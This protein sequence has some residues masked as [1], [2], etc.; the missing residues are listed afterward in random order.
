MEST[1]P[2]APPPPTSA[3][4]FPRPV[5]FVTQPP[6]GFVSVGDPSSSSSSSSSRDHPV[7]P[8]PSLD[9]IQA[10]RLGWRGPT[11]YSNWVVRGRLMAGGYPGDSVS[12]ERHEQTV[13]ALLAAGVTTFVCL[14]LTSELSSRFRPYREYAIERHRQRR[15]EQNAKAKATETEI[16]GEGASE[17][18][19]QFLH[20][21]IPDQYVVEDE[22]VLALVEELL[23]RFHAGE[24][25]YIHCWGGHGRTGTI[26]ACLL[27]RLHGFTGADGAEKTLDLT[28]ALHCCRVRKTSSRSPQHPIQYTQVRRLVAGPAAESLADG[29][30][31]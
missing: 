29:A 23:V 30:S 3:A 2:G 18:E 4:D 9:A 12:T 25:M 6:P 17:R 13:D 16:V 22:K 1:V 14:Q 20:F 31:S 24:V 19:L 5:Q 7:L 26:V 28:A 8:A 27:A 21:P 15:E 11:D 10:D